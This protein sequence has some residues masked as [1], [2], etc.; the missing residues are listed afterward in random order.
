MKKY[1]KRGDE[2]SKAAYLGED[3]LAPDWYRW[4][5]ERA[6]A[7][8]DFPRIPLAVAGG[9]PVEP[10]DVAALADYINAVV[11]NG[12]QPVELLRAASEAWEV[13]VGANPGPHGG[14]AAAAAAGPSEVEAAYARA[15][16]PNQHPYPDKRCGT[17]FFVLQGDQQKEPGQAGWDAGMHQEYRIVLAVAAAHVWASPHM[18]QTAIR[19]I[20]RRLSAEDGAETETET[21]T[22]DERTTG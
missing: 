15:F 17:K 12:Y 1:M 5:L 19:Q 11:Q 7:L 14:A 8:A 3:G 6:A 2:W 20:E 4:G 9:K 21:E 13:A 18:L 22:E 16:C 10:G